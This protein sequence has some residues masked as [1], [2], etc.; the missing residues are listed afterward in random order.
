LFGEFGPGNV[1]EEMM[2]IKLSRSLQVGRRFVGTAFGE[3]KAGT[4]EQGRSRG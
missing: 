4:G 3:T 2:G 1:N